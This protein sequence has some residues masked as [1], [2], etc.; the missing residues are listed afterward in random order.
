MKLFVG[1]ALV[2]ISS[3]TAFSQ[4]D[5]LKPGEIRFF[6][7]FQAADGNSKVLRG[8]VMI[9]TPNVVIRADSA[10]YNAQTGDIRASG[11]VRINLK[12]IT[13]GK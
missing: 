7:Q 11:N 1:A 12:Q 13:R 3:V 4:G 6:S 2:L 8:N 5:S 10:V 9:E